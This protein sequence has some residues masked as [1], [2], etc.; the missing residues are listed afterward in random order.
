M[1]GWMNF[2]TVPVNV[3]EGEG[4]GTFCEILSDLLGQGRTDMGF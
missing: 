3:L 1:F 2:L 4:G